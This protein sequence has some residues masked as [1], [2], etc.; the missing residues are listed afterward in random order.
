MSAN[1][2]AWPDNTK[3]TFGSLEEGYGH[4]SDSRRANLFKENCRG[5]L[6]SDSC[7]RIV[8]LV[9]PVGCSVSH[10]KECERLLASIQ[11]DEL[12]TRWQIFL[13]KAAWFCSVPSNVTLRCSIALFPGQL[14]SGGQDLFWAQHSH[15]INA[16]PFCW[17]AFFHCPRSERT[18]SLSI[19]WMI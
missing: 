12:L 15:N 14:F 3:V 6:I 18:P 4:L 8:V 11:G 7:H 2:I 10:D 9:A 1:H 13:A 19:S 17:G 16:W 5:C